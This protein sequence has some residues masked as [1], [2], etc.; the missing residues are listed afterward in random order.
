M[1]SCAL[2][3]I[4]DNLRELLL[5]EESDNAGLYSEDE[6]SELLWRLF[7]HIALGGPCCQYEVCNLWSAGPQDSKLALLPAC[8]LYQHD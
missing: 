6:R 7:E 8:W 1:T 5:C 3:Q 2:P 4:H